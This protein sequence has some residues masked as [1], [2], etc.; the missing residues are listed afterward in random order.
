MESPL[1]TK[2]LFDLGPV[3]VAEA[4]ATTWVIVAVLLLGSFFSTRRLRRIPGMWQ[5]SIEIFVTGIEQQIKDVIRVDPEPFLP[6]IG[7]LFLFLV[8]ANLSS[9][10]PGVEAPTATLETTA[11]LAVIVFFAVHAFG[12]WSRGLW[13]HFKSYVE[14]RAFMLP[15]NILSEI[16][17]TFALMIRLFGNMMSG[18]FMGAVII[19]LAG[20]IVP[21]PFMAL[22]LLIGLVQ[23][24]IFAVLAAVFVSAA[25]AQRDESQIGKRKE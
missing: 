7:T 19:A 20:L 2:I 3:P 11:A 14:P 6:L 10:L 24:Y 18:Q 17:R 15:L 12:I 9:L 23:A 13:G 4:V 22:D 25:I 1:E 21:V 5:A 8:V 16:T